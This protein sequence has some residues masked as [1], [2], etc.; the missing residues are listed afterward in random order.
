MTSK[1]WVTLDEAAVF[2]SGGTPSKANP[3]YWGGD[4]PWV[5]AKDMKSFRLSDTEDHVTTS[6]AANGTRLAPPGSTLVLT[7]GMTL[8][9]DV[10][11]CVANRPVTFN[12]DVKALVPRN[13]VDG[14]YLSYAIINAKP[15]LLGN[16]ELAGHGTGKLPTDVLKRLTIYLPDGEEQRTVARTLG[17]IDDKIE[18]NRRTSET[19]EAMARALFQ[20]WFVDFDPVRAKADGEPEES[21]CARL[22]LTPELLALFPDSL[23]PSALGDVPAGWA[24]EGLNCLASLTSPSVSPG[25]FPDE[26]F[27]H[28]SIPA[29]D[30]WRAPVYERGEAIKSN[31]YRVLPTAVLVSKLNPG[32]PRVWLPD[33]K[34]ARA[35]CSTEFMQFEPMRGGDRSFLYLLLQS[36][37]VQ[38]AI[39]QRVT[40]STGSRQRAQPSQIA[41]LPVVVPPRSLRDLS[42]EVF[43]PLLNRVASASSEILLL[44]DA[45]DLL[46]PRL[47]SGQLDLRPLI[48]GDDDV[49]G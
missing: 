43:T 14:E 40:G 39:Q 10:P 26:V 11:I 33:V 5:S 30:A 31:K 8:L 22:R 20:S 37:Y 24:I 45:R 18:L 49:A 46:L 3:D 2:F 7:R 19:L 16:V 48:R 12:Q 44:A 36:S 17:S 38:A 9:S 13:G 34:T 32:T 25:A 42:H 41:L 28:F 35:V 1:R 21:I 29:Y 6:G 4:V 15:E 27:E 23:E 47:L